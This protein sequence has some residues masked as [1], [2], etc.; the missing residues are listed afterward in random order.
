MGDGPPANLPAGLD[1]YAGYVNVS[2]IGRTWG[3]IQAIPA[4]WH[5]SITTDGSPADCADVESG[6]MSDWSGFTVG[7]CAISRAAGLIAQFGRPRK[8]WTAHRKK[9]AAG[10]D[11]PHICDSTCGFGFAGVADGTQWT[12]HGGA[13][14]E[15]LLFDSFFDYQPPERVLEVCTMFEDSKGR[16]CGAAKDNGNFLVITE[17]GPNQWSVEDVTDAIAGANPHD[18]RRYQLT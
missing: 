18:P 12:D 16:Y 4:R 6:A 5:L 17:T 14:D 13:W 9:D 10:R 3:A 15:S 1:A 8:L 11:V 7:Y 2:G